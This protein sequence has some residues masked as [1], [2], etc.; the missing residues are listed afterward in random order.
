MGARSL[1]EDHVAATRRAILDAARRRFG[2]DGFAATSIDDVAVEARVTKGAVYHHFSSKQAL[3]RAVYD[4]VEREAQAAPVDVPPGASVLERLR[5]GA[6]AYLDA[7]M[8]PAVRRITLLD[9]P[10]VLGPSPDGPPEEQAGHVG[11]RTFLDAAIRAGELGDLDADAVA[12]LV[13][14]ACLQAALAIASAPDPEA[15]RPRV[16][17]V[18]DAMLGGLAPPVRARTRRRPPAT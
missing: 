17:A 18:L 11:L 1:Q 12:H 13:R 5:R 16:G 3:F 14:G 9:A 7:A 10:A 15:A 2:R 4:E 6:A 8:D